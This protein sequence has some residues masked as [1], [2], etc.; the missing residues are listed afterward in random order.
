MVR[1]GLLGV[2]GLRAR[3]GWCLGSGGWGE[4]RL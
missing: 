2:G 1:R 3:S 4:M